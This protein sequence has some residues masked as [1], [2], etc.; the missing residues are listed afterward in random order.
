MGSCA[1][2]HANHEP[3]SNVASPT[4]VKGTFRVA[5]LGTQ[6]AGKSTFVKQMKILN[7]GGFDQ[8]EVDNY[9]QGIRANYLVFIKDL[10]NRIEQFEFRVSEENAKHFRYFK[11]LS[12]WDDTEWDDKLVE[13]MKKLFE[14]DAVA[15][16]LRNLTWKPLV[17][18]D[19]LLQH[20]DR[21]TSKDYV[22]TEEDILMLRQ[23]TTGQS[24]MTFIKDKHK[25][26][27]IDLGGQESEREKWDS[28]I[29]ENEIHAVIYL[30]ALDE[31]NTYSTSEKSATTMDTSMEVFKT[32]INDNRLKNITRILFLNKTDL[33]QKKVAVD[34]HFKD[35]KRA[36]PDFNGEQDATEVQDFIKDKYTKL[37]RGQDIFSH[38]KHFLPAL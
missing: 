1:S 35:F 15:K 36:F 3:N 27:I 17:Q 20:F 6:G 34:E 21:L 24:A 26:E 2:K 4:K 19:Y 7:C 22:P 23:R 13:K 16:T 37:F 9:K 38:S 30:A 12:I 8:I 25:W 18:V 11:E 31:F 29:L 5:L 33:L 32:V 14:D 10:C 28:V